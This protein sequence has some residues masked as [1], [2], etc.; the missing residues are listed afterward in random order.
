MDVY[1]IKTNME[2]E[3]RWYLAINRGDE[4]FFPEIEFSEE[5]PFKEYIEE[6]PENEVVGPLDRPE[7][8]PTCRLD[9]VAELKIPP[10]SEVV[11]GEVS[12][13]AAKP[14]GWQMQSEPDRDC[15]WAGS[16]ERFDPIATFQD[17]YGTKL[18]VTYDD[19]QLVLLLNTENHKSY[20]M[21]KWWPP[22]VVRGLSS[23]IGAEENDA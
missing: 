16:S 19:K 23:V 13:K 12:L 15:R 7:D 8:V 11:K 9:R 17:E 14:F 3:R 6:F 1:W 22:E 4:I 10:S 20:K 5:M 2:G 21:T 18:Q